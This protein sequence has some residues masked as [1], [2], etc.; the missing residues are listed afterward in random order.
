MPSQSVNMV[1][2][3]STTE[4]VVPQGPFLPCF[5]V[6]AGRSEASAR[7]VEP[8]NDP[9]EAEDENAPTGIHP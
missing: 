8:G 2:Q 4:P 6:C 5:G 7:I 3:P 9:V 1:D